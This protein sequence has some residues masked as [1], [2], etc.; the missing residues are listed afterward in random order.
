ME[1]GNITV[2][3]S[4]KMEF[5]DITSEL[6]EAIRKTEAKDGVLHVY[7]PHTTAGLTI[8]EGADPMV[9]SD[10]LGVLRLMAP[11]NYDYRHMEGNSPAH[12]MTSLV[13]SSVMAFVEDGRVLLGAWQRIFFY[14]YD[15]P[16]RRKINFRLL[17]TS[18]CG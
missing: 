8:N 7:S 9:R 18:P 11:S 13:G 14:E 2:A 12:V 5:V 17:P 4:R 10:I 1:K 3:T 15:G 6:E 16:R